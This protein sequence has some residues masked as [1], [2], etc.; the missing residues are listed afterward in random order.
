MDQKTD[1]SGGP[2]PMYDGLLKVHIWPRFTKKALH[3]GVEKSLYKFR[4][5]TIQV[6]S[7]LT[8]P[9]VKG[10]LVLMLED[11]ICYPVVHGIISLKLKT[12]QRTN[13]TAWIL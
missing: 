7:L 1:F 11:L 3:S 12:V 6:F 2:R 5:S 10:E 9:R 8:F 13:K 4:D